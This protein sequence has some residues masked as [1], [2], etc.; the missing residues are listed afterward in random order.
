V[1]EAAGK[2]QKV[3]VISY[4]RGQIAVLDRARL[5]GLSCECYAVVKEETDRLLPVHLPRLAL[6]MGS[7]EP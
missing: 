2:L 5:E 6:G 1:T 4:R 7:Q 3:G